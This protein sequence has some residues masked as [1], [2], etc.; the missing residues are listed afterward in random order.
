MKTPSLNPLVWLV[1]VCSLPL[2]MSPLL[3]FLALAQNGS[4]TFLWLE[5]FLIAPFL[6]ALLTLIVA[7]FCLFNHRSRGVAARCLVLAA[8]LAVSTLGGFRLGSRVRM[9]AFHGLAQRST[10]LL[11]AIRSYESKYGAPPQDLAALVPEFL[12]GIPGTGMAAYPNYEYHVGKNAARYDGN[13]WVVGVFTPTG[14]INF[15]QFIFYPL[16]N[17]PESGCMGRFERIADWAYIHE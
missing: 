15:D 5:M 13:P 12:P 16:Q 6:A 14:L 9:A 8:V 7:P 17:Y 4:E 11:Q 10:P 3:Q 2:V 1:P